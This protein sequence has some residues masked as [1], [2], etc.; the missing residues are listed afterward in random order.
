MVSLAAAAP[1]VERPR[2][3]P[4]ASR[5]SRRLHH[6]PGGERGPRPASG[7]SPGPPPP[8]SCWRASS[9]RSARSCPGSRSTRTAAGRRRPPPGLR[10]PAGCARRCCAR[11]EPSR[12]YD[13]TA[14]FAK[15]QAGPAPRTTRQARRQPTGWPAWRRSR[16]CCSKAQRWCSSSWRSARGR[17]VAPR[18]PRRGASL[19][20]HPHHLG[21]FIR[22]PLTRV[23]GEQHEVRRR[24]PSSPALASSGAP[25]AWARRGRA[26]IWPFPAVG[27]LLPTGRTGAGPGAAFRRPA[28]RA[29]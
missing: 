29:A 2:S 7:R 6:R 18:R 21:V 20:H 12:C 24:A 10:S 16:R 3:S 28:A 22:A 1:V 15:D 13:E 23:P 25:R 5:L 17:T 14:A 19:R 26:V 8:W 11:P 9:R 27:R 4:P